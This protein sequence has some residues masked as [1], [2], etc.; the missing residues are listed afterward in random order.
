MKKEEK[1]YS[2]VLMILMI[3]CVTLSIIS[4]SI[5]IYDKFF[6]KD[7]IERTVLKPVDN[8][9][10]N[11]VNINGLEEILITN[12]N[13]IVKVGKV[14]FQIK[15]G[16]HEDNDDILF[17][18]NQ[19]VYSRN[20]NIFVHADKAYIT[21]QFIIFTAAGQCGMG[22]V[23]AV[24]QNNEEITVNDN[25]YQIIRVDSKNNEM[26]F[27]GNKCGGMD[28]YYSDEKLVLKYLDHTL[29]VTGE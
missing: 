3:I 7:T 28:E 10:D 20:H 4:L 22:I 18:N 24:N 27:I 25:T 5:V 17:I 8:R 13:Q 19:I 11:L 15:K 14:E 1:N 9:Q 6:K 26:Y 21:N 2:K 23:Y 29:I 16:K 12:T